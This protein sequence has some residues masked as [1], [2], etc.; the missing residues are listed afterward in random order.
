MRP[1]NESYDTRPPPRYENNPVSSTV[2][3]ISRDFQDPASL[4]TAQRGIW[5]SVAEI[6]EPANFKK[7]NFRQ[8]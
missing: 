2:R 4:A 6:L 1:R 8:R 7:S 3:S 5:L